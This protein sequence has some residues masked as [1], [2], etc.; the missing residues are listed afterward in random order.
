MDD[1]LCGEVNYTANKMVYDIA[2]GGAVLVGSSVK[3]VLNNQIL[4]L[5]EVQVFGKAAS[6]HRVTKTYI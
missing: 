4:T 6:S 2:C 1:V 5:C 3:V